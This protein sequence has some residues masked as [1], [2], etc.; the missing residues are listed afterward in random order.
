MFLHVCLLDSILPVF[1][2]TL[3]I[4]AQFVINS[5]AIIKRSAHLFYAFSENLGGGGGDE[6]R[7]RFIIFLLHGLL[8]VF[9]VM[10]N[11]SLDDPGFEIPSAPPSAPPSSDSLSADASPDVR[12]NCIAC[13]RRMNKKAVDRHTLCISCRSFDCNIDNRCEE[14][15]E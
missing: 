9:P 14:C 2:M 12:R 15:M 10:G 5:H 4:R 1:I 11:F 7:L 8:C 13:P 3:S 6:F